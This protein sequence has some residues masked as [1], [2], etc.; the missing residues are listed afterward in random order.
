MPDY[1]T[2]NYQEQG[3]DRR[4]VASGGSLDVES[5]GEIDVESGA[6]LKIAGTDLTSEVAALS[7]VTATAAELNRAADVSA[8]VVNL[9][10]ASLAITELLHDGKVITVNKADGS[11]LT[12]PVA[13]GS[14]AHIIIFIGTTVSS[15]AVVVQAGDAD[16][17]FAGTAWMANDT[18]A[19][20]SGFEAAA[21]DDTITLNGSTKGGIKG[22]RIEL[23]DV[24]ANTWSV[25]AFLQGTGSEATPFSSA[26]T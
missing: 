9:T 13:T 22:D 8:R 16:D 4:V 7:G 6:A 18:D 10:A 11:T 5:G 17:A 19:S 14:G 23:I 24:A 21:T 15:S 26:V 2:K 3:G 1:Q 20:V 25:Q 12:L